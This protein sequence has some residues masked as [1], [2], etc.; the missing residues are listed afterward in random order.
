MN[1]RAGNTGPNLEKFW[2]ILVYS[3]VENFIVRTFQPEFLNING[4]V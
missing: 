1:I 2:E 3:I 4:G